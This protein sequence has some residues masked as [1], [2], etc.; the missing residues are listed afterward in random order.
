MQKP[1]FIKSEQLYNLTSS[2][3]GVNKR[4]H[5][6]PKSIALK[7]N[8]ITWLEFELADFNVAVKL[9]S[10]NATVTLQ[11]CVLNELR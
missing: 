11:K 9:V 3:M 7:V 5:A 8:V 6:F 10:H 4:V 2:L 1:V